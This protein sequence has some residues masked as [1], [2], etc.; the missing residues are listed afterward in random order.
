MRLASLL[1]EYAS[2][3]G[4]DHLGISPAAN[5]EA[6]APFLEERRDQLPPFLPRDW[7]QSRQLLPMPAP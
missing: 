6:I 7:G 2:E 4:I 3:L 1:K 5:L